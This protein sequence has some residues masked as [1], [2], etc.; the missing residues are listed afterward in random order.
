MKKSICLFFLL[1]FSL[2]QSTSLLAGSHTQIQKR[3]MIPEDYYNFTSV[4]NLQISPDGKEIAFIVSKV[5][6]DKKSRESCIWIV[7]SDGSK[8]P[9]RFTRGPKDRSPRWTPDGKHI[10]F[11]SGRD[12]KTQVY[13]ISTQG[14]EAYAITDLEEG[15]SSFQWSPDRKHILL[16]RRT[17]EG[18]KK[19][20]G[21]DDE[22]EEVKPDITVIKNSKYRANGVH[23]YL[24]KKR[25]HLWMFDIESKLT[26]QITKGQDWNDSQPV[27]SPD[28][29]QIA[30][31]SDRTGKEYEGSQNNDIWVISAQ[32]DSLKQITTQA[33]QDSYPQWSPDGKS[34]AYLRTDK[35]YAKSEIYVVSLEQ[36]KHKCLTTDLDRNFR[37]FQWSPSGRYIYFSDN[38]RGSVRLFRLDVQTGKAEKLNQDPV[39]LRNLSISRDGTLLAFTLEDEKRLSEIWVSDAL[40]KNMRQLTNYNT[41]L[42]QSLKLSEAEEYWFT[43]DAGI[44]VQCFLFKPIDWQQGKEYPLILNIHG[45]PSG[46]WGHSWFHE[47]QMLA[48]KGYAVYVVNYRGSTGYGYEFQDAVRFDYGG[49]DYQDNLQGVDDIVKRIEWVDSNRLGITGGSHGGYL[50]NWII[51]Q[52]DRFKAAVTQRSISNWISAHGEQDFTPQQMRTEFNG[53]PW[54]NFNLYWDRSPIKYADR[55]KTPT[56]II[57]SDQDYRCPLGQAQELFYALKIHGIP[58]EMV[59][60]NGES[61]GLSRTGKPINLVERLERLIDWFD[62]YL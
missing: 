12:K 42:L 8:D 37:G 7:P 60:F 26:T 40:G 41:S 2:G 23:P 32:G 4:S 15:V 47:F 6:E 1:L 5:S 21:E 51:T 3:G 44:K 28:G 31:V 50:T 27:L 25:S 45:G 24:D 53:T 10:A 9:I 58:T 13:L 38:D 36:S 43:N 14:G 35:P 46:M 39:S 48:A 56:L 22:K 55:I 49:V 33:N 52:T 57:H 59:I 20:E 18:A 11:L 17:E 61:H 54:E 29:K 16:V 34:I 19:K 30:F 62:R